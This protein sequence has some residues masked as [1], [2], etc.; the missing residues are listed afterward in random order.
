[1]ASTWGDGEKEREE[2]G[3]AAINAQYQP[4]LYEGEMR[5]RSECQASL[6]AGFAMDGATSHSACPGPQLQR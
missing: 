4:A 1:M 5:G 3:A 2:V 6:F